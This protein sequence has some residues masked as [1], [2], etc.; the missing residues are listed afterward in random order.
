MEFL[1]EIYFYTV[2]SFYFF[3]LFLLII[4]TYANEP[5]YPADSSSRV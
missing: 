5:I 1:N 2:L 3:Y 4:H